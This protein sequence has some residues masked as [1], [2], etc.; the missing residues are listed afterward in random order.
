ML[1]CDMVTYSSSRRAGKESVW[2]L[3]K[4]VSRFSLRVCGSPP[5]AAFIMSPELEIRA[6]EEECW[7]SVRGEIVF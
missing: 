5:L 1:S 2:V 3:V 4:T 7:R 6:R